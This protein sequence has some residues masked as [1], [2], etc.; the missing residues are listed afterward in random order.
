MGFFSRSSVGRIDD[1]TTG[2]KGKGLWSSY[3]NYAA[4]HLEGGPGTKQKSVKFQI[5]PDPL[6]K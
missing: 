2:W 5:R 4:W 3:S 6:A 1:A